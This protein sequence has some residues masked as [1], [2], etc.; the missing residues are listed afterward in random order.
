MPLLDTATE[1][2]YREQFAAIRQMPRPERFKHSI[3]DVK[4]G[5]YIRFEG[6]SYQGKGLNDYERQGYR[7]PELAIY[8]LNNGE[9]SY[10]EWEKEDEVTVFVS[11]EKLDFVKVGL[12]NKENLCKISDDESGEAKYGHH[13]F[14]YHEDSAVMFFR[15]QGEEGTRFHQYLFASSD[16]KAFIAIEEWGDDD[17]GYEHNVILS[18][19]VDPKAIDVLSVGGAV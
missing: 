11:R 2:H 8:C 4:A 12:K 3:E 1:T 18:E 7:W 13:T 6:K 19:H 10:L 14:S 17:E 15:D 9:T 5:G 16:R